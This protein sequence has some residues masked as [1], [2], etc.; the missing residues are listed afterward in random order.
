MLDTAGS[1]HRREVSLRLG[2]A[3][4]KGPEVGTLRFFFS[5]TIQDVADDGQYGPVMAALYGEPNVRK[6][7]ST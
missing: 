6:R 2:G 7:R 5:S 3:N 4:V 1:W